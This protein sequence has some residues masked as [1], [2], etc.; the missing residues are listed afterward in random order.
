MTYKLNNVLIVTKAGHSDARDLAQSIAALLK[1]SGVRVD[2]AEHQVCSGN[3]CMSVESRDLLLVLGGDGTMISVAREVAGR[4]PLLGVN[5]GRLGFLTELS[6]DDWQ[7]PLARLVEQGVIWQ[8]RMSLDWEVMRGGQLLSSGVVINDIVVNRGALARL[9][10]LSMTLGGEALGS[11]RADGLVVATPTGSTAYSMSSGG[12]I[13][14]PDLAVFTVTPIC[15][16]LSNFKPMVLPGPSE[17]CV[18]VESSG[19]EVFLTLDGQDFVT[20]QAHD[21]I[22]VTRSE[23]GMLLVDAGTSSY[24]TRLKAKGVIV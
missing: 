18:C 8:E 7:E 20:L 11:L 19:T 13:V 12:P 21:I 3:A 4:V 1:G 22:R 2:I 5:L 9:V 15:P 24:V 16:F 6:A 23:A 17:L 10:H 14:H